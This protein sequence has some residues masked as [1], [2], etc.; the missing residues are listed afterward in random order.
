MNDA[1]HRKHNDHSLNS[2]TYHK[3]DGTNVRSKLKGETAEIVK[4]DT[5]E[6]ADKAVHQVE[7]EWH[8]PILTKYGFMP[9]SDTGMGF[10]RHCDYA[11]EDGEVIRATTGHTADYWD[12]LNGTP[13]TQE[14]RYWADLEP[15]L[16]T[17]KVPQ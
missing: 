16:K 4:A 1:T 9:I 15:H 8:Y 6:E 12:V 13:N 14:K 5:F 17:L 7:N 10:V 11:R 3:K 2:S